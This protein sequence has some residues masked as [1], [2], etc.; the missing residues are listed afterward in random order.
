MVSRKINKPATEHLYEGLDVGH[1]Y[2]RWPYLS[3]TFLE[4]PNPAQLVKSLTCHVYDDNLDPYPQMDF[5]G[6][7]MKKV[8]EICDPPQVVGYLAS[9]LVNGEH[10]GFCGLMLTLL[11]SLQSLDFRVYSNYGQRISDEPLQGIYGIEI[12]DYCERD[13]SLRSILNNVCTLA[14]PA[15]HLKLLHFFLLPRLKTL[16]LDLTYDG[17]TGNPTPHFAAAASEI[18]SR[19]RIKELLLDIEWSELE[20]ANT[21]TWTRCILNAMQGAEGSDSSRHNID[22]Y[23]L[24]LT[25][26]RDHDRGSVMSF[27]RLV[28]SLELQPLI[29]HLRVEL[30]SPPRIENRIPMFLT[31]LGMMTGL[32]HCSRLRKLEAIQEFLKIELRCF[33]G[34][35]RLASWFV[36]RHDKVFEELHKKD[37]A[38]SIIDC[39]RRPFESNNDY[40]LCN[41]HEFYACCEDE[42]GII[43]LFSQEEED[44]RQGL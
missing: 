9:N 25:D 33:R 28:S 44:E 11:P 5:I 43:R 30:R 36:K 24:R 31:P 2:Y 1:R 41:L 16:Q 12:A 27:D 35:G 7:A 23:V 39:D 34:H 26:R 6:R 20:T 17:G 38:V 21:K 29:N 32:S 4:C 37:V 10:T 8:V 13:M 14:I 22:K 19:T 3:R 15:C 42:A 18:L 40:T